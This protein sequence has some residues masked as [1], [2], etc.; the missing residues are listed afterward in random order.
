VRRFV[1]QRA[2]LLVDGNVAIPVDAGGALAIGVALDVPGDARWRRIPAMI[3]DA[4]R[5][6]ADALADPAEAERR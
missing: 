4:A 6:L 1:R 2:S 5:R 3:D